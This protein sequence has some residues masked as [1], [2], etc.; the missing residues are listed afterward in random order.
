M[1]VA[2][3]SDAWRPQINGVVRAFVATVEQ[4]RAVGHEMM[5]VTSGRFR[6]LPCPSYPEI[7]LT[8][9]PH[10]RVRRMLRRFA[11][12][13]VHIATEGPLVWAARGWCK[14]QNL[15]SQVRFTLASPTMSL[16]AP[17]SPPGCC[18]R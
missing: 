9:W 17:G 10:P 4:L 6:T 15:P 11:P 1:R 8:L 16:S 2:I 12:D 14:S 3:V 18:G 5:T 7:R 13:A